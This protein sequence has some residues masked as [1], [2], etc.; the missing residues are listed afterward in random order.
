MRALPK[1]RRRN[2]RAA[3]ALPVAWQDQRRGVT[4]VTTTIDLSAS[5]LSLSS[6]DRVPRW[7]PVYLV[8]GHESL[9]LTFEAPARVVR[10]VPVGDE[11]MVG[12]KFGELTTSA[13]ADIGRFV[14]R[15]IADAEAAE[16]A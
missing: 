6:P 9:G 12:V 5:G 8:V 3:V 16:A 13:A 11:Y 4:T 2:L 10:S 1:T 7:T 15:Q 14:V